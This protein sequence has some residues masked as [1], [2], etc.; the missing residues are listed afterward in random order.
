MAN[1]K[2]FLSEIESIKQNSILIKRK[3]GDIETLHSK[4]LAS[5]GEDKDHQKNLDALMD[6]ANAEIQKTRKRIKDLEAK[7]KKA[8]AEN[9]KANLTSEQ[10]IRLTQTTNV[11]QKFIEVVTEYQEVQQKYKT[12]FKDRL[13]RQFKIVKPN[14]TKEEVEKMVESPEPQLFAQQ[15]LLGPQHAEAKKA[16]YDIQERHQDIVKLEKSIL[17]LHQ[18]F[19]DMAVMVDAQ[20]DMIN[21]IENYV[22]SAADNTNKGVEEMRKAVKLQKASR[23][24]MCCVLVLIIIIVIV[25]A[26]AVPLST[27]K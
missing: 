26:V 25:V 24:K 3:V 16:L 22:S 7:N 17:E 6:D 15:I 20:G 9:G 8:G 12:K 23:K 14:A 2:E 21:Q 4:T 11:T 10:R 27:S 19:L 5:I 13:E 18:L 1:L